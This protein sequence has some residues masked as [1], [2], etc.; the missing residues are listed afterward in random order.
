MIIN[1]KLFKTNEEFIAWQKEKDRK[2]NSIVPMISSV[3]G[4][5]SEDSISLETNLM[6]F[7]TFLEEREIPF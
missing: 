7:V 6:I 5:T 1:Y 4:D 3:G 2:I